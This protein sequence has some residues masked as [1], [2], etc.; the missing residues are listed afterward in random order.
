MTGRCEIQACQNSLALDS[1]SH[2][3]LTAS[4]GEFLSP[5]TCRVAGAK[6]GVGLTPRFPEPPRGLCN[7]IDVGGV[8]PDLH[9]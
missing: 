5:F 6:V 2:T 1:F 4:F 3:R 8:S 7:A 9:H